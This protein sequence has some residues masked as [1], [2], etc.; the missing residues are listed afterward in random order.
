MVAYNGHKWVHDIKFQSS[1]WRN[2]LITNLVTLMEDR[3]FGGIMFYKSGLL[4]EL[5]GLAWFKNQ[6]LC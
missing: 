1:V 2:G 5:Q 4:N 3:G 6:I